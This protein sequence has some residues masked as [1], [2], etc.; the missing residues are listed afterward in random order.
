MA[1]PR[2]WLMEG[3]WSNSVTDRSSVQPALS[4]LEELKLAKLTRRHINREDDLVEELR[5]WG[6]KSNASYGVGYLALHG[7]PSSVYVRSEK[8]PLRHLADRLA[9]LDVDLTGRVL[10]MGSCA[11]LRRKEGA[12][13]LLDATGLSLITGYTKNVDWVESMAFDLLLIGALTSY[14]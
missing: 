8:V 12:Q 13:K 5:K 11:V 9:D 4:I 3:E 10:H 6:L 14:T 7:T 2:I 1:I